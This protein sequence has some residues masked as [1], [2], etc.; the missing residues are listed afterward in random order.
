MTGERSNEDLRSGQVFTILP[1]LVEKVT[2]QNSYSFS[3]PSSQGAEIYQGLS[4]L[5]IYFP[6]HKLV[7]CK[8][9]TRNVVCWTRFHF[10]IQ[11]RIFFTYLDEKM[12]LRNNQFIFLSF[13]ESEFHTLFW[14]YCIYWCQEATLKIF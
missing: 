9:R 4:L 10:M 6:L 2:C 13:L 7:V 1:V 11:C 5:F 8:L 14:A 12:S 3:R